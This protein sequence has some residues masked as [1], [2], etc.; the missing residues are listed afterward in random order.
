RLVTAKVE[1]RPG[2]ARGN[3]WGLMVAPCHY[4]TT[5]EPARSENLCPSPLQ[6]R[7]RSFHQL[8]VRCAGPAQ[9]ETAGG[10]IAVPPRRAEVSIIF[11]HRGAELVIM[12]VAAFQE[13]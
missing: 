10:Q 11:Q 9:I 8:I 4:R 12:R 2:K 6:R 7:A 13:N 3:W 1:N 5:L